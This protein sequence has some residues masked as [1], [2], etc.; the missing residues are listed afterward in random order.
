MKPTTGCMKIS[1]NNRIRVPKPSCKRT[2]N[3]ELKCQNCDMAPLQDRSMPIWR[4]H[5]IKCRNFSWF[6]NVIILAEVDKELI[7]EKFIQCVIMWPP[8]ESKRIKRTKTN[9]LLCINGKICS[10]NTIV[11]LV[12]RDI[13]L[14]HPKSVVNGQG[15]S[16]DRV[17]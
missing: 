2:F 9:N 17:I 13:K 11:G 8:E 6:S 1:R 12:L 5:K 15:V 16:Q 4:S 14:F 10:F 7:R 3:F